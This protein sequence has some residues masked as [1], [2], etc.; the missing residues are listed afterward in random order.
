MIEYL[1][2]YIWIILLC[3]LVIDLGILNC[4]LMVSSPSF[5]NWMCIIRAFYFIFCTPSSVFFPLLSASNFLRF[6]RLLFL[7]KSF[8][9]ISFETVV[10]VGWK[11]NCKLKM[12]SISLVWKW[13]FSVSEKTFGW[14]DT[15]VKTSRDYLFHFLINLGNT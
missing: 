13:C 5:F 3:L 1:I 4:F 12:T 7:E 8:A 11:L 10:D 15:L 14:I 2:L 6:S 9:K